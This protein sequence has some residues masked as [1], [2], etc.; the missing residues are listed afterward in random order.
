MFMPFIESVNAPRIQMFSTMMTQIPVLNYHTEP[1]IFTG[2]EVAHYDY[3][4]T[5][6]NVPYASKVIATVYK[7][8]HPRYI[9]IRYMDSDWVE[10]IDYIDALEYEC[11]HFSYGYKFN[12]LNKNIPTYLAKDEV[13]ARTNT[14]YDKE[15]WSPGI[16]VETMGSTAPSVNQDGVEI[17]HTLRNI[18]ETTAYKTFTVSIGDRLPLNIYGDIYGNEDSYLIFPPKGCKVRDDGLLIATRKIDEYLSPV[19]MTKKKLKE[20]DYSGDIDTGIIVP[21]DS[22]VVDVKVIKNTSHIKYGRNGEQLTPYKVP[23]IMSKQLSEYCE[24]DELLKSQITKMYEEQIKP[25]IK[26]DKVKLTNSCNWLIT[27]SLIFSDSNKHLLNSIPKVRAFDKLDEWELTITVEYKVKPII[28]S[29]CS[30]RYGNKGVFVKFTPTEE[31]PRYPGTDI[32]AHLIESSLSVNDRMNFAREYEKFICAAVRDLEEYLRESEIPFY[33]KEERLKTFLFILNPRSALEY[34]TDPKDPNSPLKDGVLSEIIKPRKYPT[35]PNLK[36]HM[37]TDIEEELPKIIENLIKEGFSPREEPVEYVDDVGVR[38]LTK[39]KFIIGGQYIIPLDKFAD[40]HHGVAVSKRNLYSL[41]SKPTSLDK[42]KSFVKESPIRFG[43]S[44]MRAI[45]GFYGPQASAFLLGVSNNPD[46]RTKYI[47]GFYNNPNPSTSD[48]YDPKVYDPDFNPVK[49]SR[50]ID[51][52]NSF[53]ALQGFKLVYGKKD[54][55]N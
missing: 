19:L 35:A 48:V 23:G 51:L 28:G 34:L 31:M 46:E 37:P 17:S 49:G 6:K 53:H 40:T 54:E 27:N 26:E 20:Y 14:T 47:N 41:P 8:G 50:I 45:T 22:V 18:L 5:I 43:E 42:T 30:G 36:I 9:F 33:Q 1:T 13:L 55:D 3:I 12:Y 39:S 52:Q 11:N 2:A 4:R 44:E 15:M 24:K 32:V 7:D 25:M 16:Q 29:K 10:Y 38:R 21:S